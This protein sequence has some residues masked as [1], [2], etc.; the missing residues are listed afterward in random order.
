MIKLQYRQL[1]PEQIMALVI[2]SPE[3]PSLPQYSP[4][5]HESP[6]KWGYEKGGTDDRKTRLRF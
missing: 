2:G 3:F 5:E 1:E 4:Q 6:E